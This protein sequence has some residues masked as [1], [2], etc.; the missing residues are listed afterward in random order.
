MKA[1][2]KSGKLHF[3][4]VDVGK[5]NPEGLTI[6]LGHTF[7]RTSALTVTMVIV[8]FLQVIRSQP[9]KYFRRNGV[10]DT[11]AR[12]S[13]IKVLTCTFYNL[14]YFYSF[15]FTFWVFVIV[16]FS[17]KC[18]EGVATLEHTI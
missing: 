15:L 12:N 6:V 4:I 7:S 3:L 17:I 14:F 1:F 8:I 16:A 10:S 9:E 2:R 13:K 5:E 11:F 18:F